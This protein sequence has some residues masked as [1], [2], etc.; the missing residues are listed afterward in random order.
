MQPS[1][2]LNI[3]FILNPASGGKKRIHWEPIIRNYFKQLSYQIHF[4]ILSGKEDGRQL[5]IGSKK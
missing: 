4:Y 2:N 3:L 1:S 5:I